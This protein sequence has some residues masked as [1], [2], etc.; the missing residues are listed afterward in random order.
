MRDT[1]IE[2][3]RIDGDSLNIRPVSLEDK[4]VYAKATIEIELDRQQ[5]DIAKRCNISYD[6]YASQYLRMKFE[7]V[8]RL[9]DILR[10]GGKDG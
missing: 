3:L 2:E 9:T 6:E 8:K 4:P 7:R 5:A 1:Y 10:C